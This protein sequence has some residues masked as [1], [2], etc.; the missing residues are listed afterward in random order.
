MTSVLTG[1]WNAL[2]YALI[3]DSSAYFRKP[4][5]VS[6]TSTEVSALYSVVEKSVNTVAIILVVL[7]SVDTALS[8]YT[9]RP[10]CTVLVAEAFDLVAKLP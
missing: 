5:H 7:C 10:S 2:G 3:N 1:K 4:V 8:C 9:V 6:F